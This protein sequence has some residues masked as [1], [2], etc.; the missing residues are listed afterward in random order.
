MTYSDYSLTPDEYEVFL[1]AKKSKKL[2]Q[3]WEDLLNR[4][5]ED[6]LKS[7]AKTKGYQLV[8]NPDLEDDVIASY[9]MFII[10]NAST[11]LDHFI[12]ENLYPF[13]VCMKI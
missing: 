2:D 3:I 13:V 11:E 10:P 7:E 4:V 1:A 5:Q 6:S 8:D 9:K 12:R